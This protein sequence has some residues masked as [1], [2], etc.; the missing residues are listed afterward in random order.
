MHGH[1]SLAQLGERREDLPSLGRVLV[2]NSAQKRPV[3]QSAGVW[4]VSA[5]LAAWTREGGMGIGEVRDAVAAGAELSCGLVV[6]AENSKDSTG[7]ESGGAGT[8]N[9]ESAVAAGGQQDEQQDGEERDAAVVGDLDGRVAG[10]VGVGCEGAAQAFH[11][12]EDADTATTRHASCC[13]FLVPNDYD[14]GEERGGNSLVVCVA[15]PERTRKEKE[16]G[17]LRGMRQRVPLLQTSS[18]AIVQ[19]VVPV[20]ASSF[21]CGLRRDVE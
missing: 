2:P 7:E 13:A 14:Y 21:L 18:T 1:W 20:A 17:F 3:V 8:V 12:E 9:R 11:G 10:V 15:R 6:A 5:L 16:P 19:E 4:F